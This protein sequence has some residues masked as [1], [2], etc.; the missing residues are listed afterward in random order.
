MD[1]GVIIDSAGSFK[2]EYF[3]R[4]HL[5]NTR[6]TFK[7]N[8]AGFTLN[9]SADYYPFGM[10]WVGMGGENKYLYNGKELQDEIG[11]DWYDYGARFYDPQIGRWTTPDPLSETLQESFTPYH[12]CVNNPVL[13]TDPDGR[14]IPVLAV[15]AAIAVKAVVGAVIDAGVQFSVN[16]AQGMSNQEAFNRIDRTSVWAS[17]AISG[18]TA[19]GVSTTVKA[20][21]TTTA[22]IADAVVDVN[23]TD[24][25]SSLGGLA[26]TDS[27][28][29][30]NVVADA[31]FGTFG[32]KAPD[33]IVSGSKSAVSNDLN[34]SNFAPLTSSEKQLVRTTDNVVNSNMYSTAVSTAVNTTVGSSG[35]ANTVVKGV[36]QG[37]ESSP[38]PIPNIQV[39]DNTRVACST[40]FRR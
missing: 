13:Y 37:I 15:V 11:L 16:R 3:L 7:P 33:A 23:K 12:Y 6:I 17:A 2:Y 14:I 39:A 32:A 29:I 1:E 20:A 35:L 27:K 5:G 25:T 38:A 26:G 18:V 31:T 21:V 10:K 24:G 19:P 22:V 4:D 9:Q 36:I 34:P 40:Y 30:F 28:P 8:G